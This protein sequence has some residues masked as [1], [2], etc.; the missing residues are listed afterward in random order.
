MLTIKTKTIWY[1]L[2]GIMIFSSMV[3]TYFHFIG[4]LL[5]G[6]SAY[7][8]GAYQVKWQSEKDTNEF[9]KLFP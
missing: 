1:T 4:M 8:A 6:L 9:K 3:M 2:L 5:F 7:T